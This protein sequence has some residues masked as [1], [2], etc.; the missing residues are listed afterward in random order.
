MRLPQL[1]REGG[2]KMRRGALIAGVV[3]IGILPGCAG[4]PLHVVM[5]NGQH[6][7]EAGYTWIANPEND[8][9]VRWTAG[10][11]HPSYPHVISAANEG[12]WSPTAGYTW[13]SLSP[14]DLSVRWG[15]GTHLPGA[16]HVIAATAQDK[17]NAEPGYV[18]TSEAI[19]NLQVIWRQGIAIQGY[20]HVVASEEEGKWRP[21]DGYAWADVEKR[22][23]AWSPGSK[24]I[25]YAH[26]FAD[27]REGYWRADAGYKF[28][29]N[30]SLEVVE[31]PQEDDGK[32]GRVVTD[33]IVAGV[34][35]KLSE[36]HD[37]D[38]SFAKNVGR[39]IAGAL[40]DAATDA[41]KKEI[42]H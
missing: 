41:A 31:S 38:S 34:F 27:D 22:L 33:V 28:V 3:T 19:D 17:W 12:S 25:K 4:V 35:N 42:S 11:L 2:Y 10:V 18:F 8:L 36:A 32:L 26:V 14:T 9:H 39:P 29:S 1:V 37:D 7:P 23:A 13:E 16:A 5:V 20:P 30:D 24:H 6:Q 21:E 15:P 40:A